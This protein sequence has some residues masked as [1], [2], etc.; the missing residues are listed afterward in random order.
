MNREALPPIWVL[1]LERSKDRRL[2]MEKQLEGLDL[3]FEIIKAVDGKALKEDDLRSYSE[4]K[5]IRCEGTALSPGRIACALSHARMWHRIIE[6]NLNEVLI[7]EDDGL[8]GESLIDIL[9]SR[10]QFPRDWEFMNFLTDAQKIPFG[11]PITENYNVCRFKGNA[12]RTTVYLIN[13]RGAEKLLKHC[14]PIRYTADGLTGRTYL[15]GLIS[16]GIEPQVATLS[17]YANDSEIWKDINPNSLKS[18]FFVR[19]RKQFMQRIT[20]RD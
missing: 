4:K 2:F 6:E 18:S 11:T 5:A 19:M 10:H 14:F 17:D 3:E 8:I 1:N 20:G 15:T 13:R 16:Y 7:L 12:N 9:R